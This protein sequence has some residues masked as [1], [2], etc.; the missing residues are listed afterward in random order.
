MRQSMAEGKIIFSDKKRLV[1]GVELFELEY[2]NTTKRF[3]LKMTEEVFKL[4]EGEENHIRKVLKHE[5]I[6]NKEDNAFVIIE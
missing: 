1:F 6:E 2:N 5:L 3:R 4:R